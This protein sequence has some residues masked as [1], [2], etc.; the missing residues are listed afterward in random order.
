MTP[1]NCCRW[2]I[3]L[4]S[5]IPDGS[6]QWGRSTRRRRLSLQDDETKS[7][8]NCGSGGFNNAFMGSSRR[9]RRVGQRRRSMIAVMAPLLL[10]YAQAA[11][12]A[13]RIVCSASS[14]RTPSTMLRKMA[15][16]CSRSWFI[17]AIWAAHG[18]P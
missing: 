6:S 3:S 8:M 17:W 11:S 16:S 5:V 4:E 14:T 2:L 13:N 7:A 12:L 1:S 10:S 9:T 18:R 15:R